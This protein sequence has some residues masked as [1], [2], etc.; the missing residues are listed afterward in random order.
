MS[1]AKETP[2]GLNVNS[3]FLQNQ[4]LTINK[5]AQKYMGISQENDSYTFGSVVRNTCLNLLT[6]AINDAYLRGVVA[7]TVAGSS[8]YDRLI[9][10]GAGVCE[11]LG[12]SKPPTYNTVNPATGVVP[13]DTPTW[14][15]EGY[16]ATTGFSISGN[17]GQG[18]EASWLPYDMTNPNHSVTQY[19]FIRLWAL[20]ANNEFNWNGGTGITADPTASVQYKDFLS[21]FDTIAS[22]IQ[23]N[24]VVAGVQQN[25]PTYLKG[26]YSN[27]NDLT[28]AD[29][30]GVSMSEAFGRDCVIAGKVIDLSK[31]SKFGLPSVLLQ[32]ISKY[33]AKT[34][35]LNI[36]LLS[37]GLS[38]DEINGIY[39]ETITNVTV[40]QEK[41]IY[42]A[43]LVI[44]GTDL[45]DILVPLNCKTK[46]LQ[47]LADL[48]NIKKLFPSSYPSLTVPVY[49]TTTGPTNSK[50]YYPIYENEGISPRL[51][52]PTIASQIGT[53]VPSGPPPVIPRGTPTLTVPNINLN[54]GPVSTA[55]QSAPSLIN[56]EER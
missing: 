20:Q 51:F 45:Q 30:S 4:G 18:Q 33:H 6:L 23:T 35:A 44:V 55:T 43:S 42:G 12:N 9:S 8:V 21:S 49:N 50:T 10:I 11:I 16:P 7:T 19:G 24:N 15:N 27:M 32:T 29:I 39:N 48:L 28:T 13:S 52:S 54:T 56:S 25:A 47:T 53:I 36:A 14:Y 40:E 34:Q 17:T 5:N 22:Y 31:I 41:Q 46:G 1:T 38:T 26:I 3:G 37:A 2:L